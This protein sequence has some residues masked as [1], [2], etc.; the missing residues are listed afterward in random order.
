LTVQSMFAQINVLIM[1]NVMMVFVFVEIFGLELIVLK[2][3]AFQNVRQMDNVLMEFA[4]V[5]MDT[6][7][8]DVKYHHV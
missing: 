4:Y 2:K 6:V 3:L 1:D 7:E 8:I 5:K